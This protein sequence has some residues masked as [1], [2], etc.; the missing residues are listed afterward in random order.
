LLTLT[1]S[2]LSCLASEL[3]DFDNLAGCDDFTVQVF[4]KCAEVDDFENFA[5]FDGFTV[6]VD[7][8]DLDD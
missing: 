3:G 6:Q 5:D 7:L 4:G 2:L 8:A 1:T